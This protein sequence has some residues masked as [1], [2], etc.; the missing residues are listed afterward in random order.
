MLHI[1]VMHIV[2]CNGSYDACFVP[3]NIFARR[4]PLLLRHH[5]FCRH[6]LFFLYLCNKLCALAARTKTKKNIMQMA[7]KSRGNRFGKNANACVRVGGWE[8]KC[9][10][11]L[12]F[13][14]NIDLCKFKSINSKHQHRSA[15]CQINVYY[16]W[17][18]SGPKDSLPLNLLV[19]TTTW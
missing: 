10:K 7:H 15:A 3:I 4:F 12:C 11:M 19:F 6:N 14:H 17:T 16:Y 5:F 8:C 13:R 9:V 1:H 2:A 18:Y